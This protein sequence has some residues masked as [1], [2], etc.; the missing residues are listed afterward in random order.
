MSGAHERLPT[1]GMPGAGA[2]QVGG[3]P[4]SGCIAIAWSPSGELMQT[5]ERPEKEKGNSHKNLKVR[6]LRTL[7]L[8]GRGR[9]RRRV[10]LCQKAAA[11]SAAS[12]AQH[13]F[14][15]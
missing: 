1:A 12:A 14:P 4:L 9:S 13:Q 11:P 3:L 8:R 5:F 6:G 15:G 7:R 10:W 2:P